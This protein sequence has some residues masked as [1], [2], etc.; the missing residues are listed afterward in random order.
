FPSIS[1]ASRPKLGGRSSR[2]APRRAS[3]RREPRPPGRMP[4]PF[5]NWR[6]PPGPEG[7]EWGIAGI[8]SPSQALA[9]G[10]GGFVGR[11]RGEGGV[12]FPDDVAV[13]LNLNRDAGLDEPALHLRGAGHHVEP[14]L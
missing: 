14:L 10:G 1:A 2:R 13:R 11:F 8:Q 7:R 12:D 3:A 4:N 5:R 9:G 6:P